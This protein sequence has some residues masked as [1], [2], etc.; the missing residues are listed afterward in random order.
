[1][2]DDGAA[3]AG[4]VSKFAGGNLRLG[5]LVDEM[6]KGYPEYQHPLILLAGAD[7]EEAGDEIAQGL[8]KLAH[9]KLEV[10]R[11]SIEP[12]VHQLLLN[13]SNREANR[14]AIIEEFYSSHKYVPF[15]AAFYFGGNPSYATLL[16]FIVAFGSDKFLG[17]ILE[18]NEL[19]KMT[20][21]KIDIARIDANGDTPLHNAVRKDDWSQ[22]ACI[23]LIELGFSPITINNKRE[24]PLSLAKSDLRKAMYEALLTTEA[25]ESGKTQLQL[26]QACLVSLIKLNNLELVQWL[27]EERGVDP[28]FNI[29]GDP[30]QLS[31]VMFALNQTMKL[32]DNV[33]LGIVKYLSGRPGAI[34]V[35]NKK[36]QN[37]TQ[38]NQAYSALAFWLM[39][40]PQSRKANPNKAIPP[41]I[42]LLCLVKNYFRAGER[43]SD[44]LTAFKEY[45]NV[46]AKMSDRKSTADDP[47]YAALNIALKKILDN[48]DTP[49]LLA[50]SPLI[51]VNSMAIY[52]DTL[53]KLKTVK[54]TDSD[55]VF[56]N[57]LLNE[58]N[59]LILSPQFNRTQYNALINLETEASVR[60]AMLQKAKTVISQTETKFNKPELELKS[61]FEFCTDLEGELQSI[62]DFICTELIVADPTRRDRLIKYAVMVR[63]FDPKVTIY[64]QLCDES[65]F[66]ICDALLAHEFMPSEHEANILPE[67]LS[68]LVDKYI[69]IKGKTKVHDHNRTK[70]VSYLRR[71]KPYCDES[72]IALSRSRVEGLNI[73]PLYD[74]FGIKLPETDNSSLSGNQASENPPTNPV[75]DIPANATDNE[76]DLP[77]AEVVASANP[78]PPSNNGSTQKP[79]NSNASTMTAKPHS[80][81]KWQ[82]K[83]PQQ[84]SPR[85]GGFNTRGHVAT[86]RRNQ[87]SSTANTKNAGDEPVQN[88]SRTESCELF[89]YN[90]GDFPVLPSRLK[91]AIPEPRPSDQSTMSR[92]VIRQETSVEIDAALWQS[93][94]PDVD[95]SHLKPGME[96]ENGPIKAVITRPTAGDKP[97]LTITAEHVGALLFYPEKVTDSWILLVKSGDVCYGIPSN[98]GQWTQK[99]SPFAQPFV[100]MSPPVQAVSAPN[101]AGAPSAAAALPHRTDPP[102]DSPG[103]GTPRVG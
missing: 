90:E 52:V 49:L 7:Q 43:D 57:A 56:M 6:V 92:V 48:R 20:K 60:Q 23:K 74:V 1:M 99:L 77:A 27:V 34:A 72:C 58:I 12:E 76:A 63:E 37:F 24:C 68:R 95:I 69:G 18:L 40:G 96:F 101:D 32:T 4:A 22:E 28:A 53:S 31:P 10:L 62:M 14:L 42:K 39:A 84:F 67:L 30:Q 36:G 15:Q 85:R 89:V 103:P 80:A 88:A 21:H 8:R 59:K 3:A 13:I 82:P 50:I 81:L 100:L 11:K 73:L 87:G 70:V 41:N 66:D 86:R 26:E 44:V 97:R 35:M 78:K 83:P 2:A 94:Q 29:E 25:S 47:L 9:Q 17:R 64:K 102:S 61:I 79:K 65:Q 16:H 38:F 5:E 51:S 93:Q 46:I 91:K 33:D 19:Q 55:T 98:S 75:G 54:R 71:V 45:L